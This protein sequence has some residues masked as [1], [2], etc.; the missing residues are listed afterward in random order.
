MR[1]SLSHPIFALDESAWHHNVNRDLTGLIQDAESGPAS[2]PMTP[3]RS[4]VSAELRVVLVP[5]V[6]AGAKNVTLFS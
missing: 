1:F 3:W 6:R 4:P 5:S 2:A